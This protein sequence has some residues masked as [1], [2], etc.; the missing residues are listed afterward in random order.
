MDHLEHLATEVVDAR[1]LVKLVILNRRL[2]TINVRREYSVLTCELLLA[3]ARDD[4]DGEQYE[5]GDGEHLDAYPG[6]DACGLRRRDRRRSH[7]AT[8]RKPRTG[9]KA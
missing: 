8:L 9:D 2:L 6:A 7:E 5:H 3:P 1:P 4:P